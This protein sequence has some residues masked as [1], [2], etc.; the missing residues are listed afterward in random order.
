MSVRQMSLLLGMVEQIVTG[1]P[2]PNPTARKVTVAE[3]QQEDPWESSSRQDDER[4]AELEWRVETVLESAEFCRKRQRTGDCACIPCRSQDKALELL[5]GAKPVNEVDA[6]GESRFVKTI[7][8]MVSDRAAVARCPYPEWRH[9]E[10]R[11]E[12]KLD[13]DPTTLPETLMD[14]AH[15]DLWRKM[16]D[17]RNTPKANGAVKLH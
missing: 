2:V 8:R 10:G 3:L 6:S 14:R 7:A 5:K 1:K 9:L 4:L 17:D 16:A 12:A 15:R 11:G 13:D